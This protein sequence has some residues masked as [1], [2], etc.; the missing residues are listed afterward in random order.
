MRHRT[1]PAV[2]HRQQAATVGVAVAEPP[3]PLCG[4]HR[5]WRPCTRT[6]AHA[7]VAQPS[8]RTKTPSLKHVQSKR[9]GPAG[10]SHQRR[11][12]EPS[13]RP[14]RLGACKG[15]RGSAAGMGGG[16]AA[17]VGRP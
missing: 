16:V 4:Y 5:H 1:P 10:S 3:P 9:K 15:A 14:S 8:L 7:P 11:G 6:C 12:G 17:P 13:Q 2:V